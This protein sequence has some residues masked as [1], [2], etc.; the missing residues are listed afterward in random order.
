MNNDAIKDRIRKL[1]NLAENDG[2]SEG[3][4]EN[5]MRF[6]QRLMAEHHL[7]EADIDRNPDQRRTPEDIA[8]SKSY[9][10][11]SVPLGA[12]KMSYWEASVSNAVQRVFS[13]HVQCYRTHPT[14]Q[15][16]TPAGLP[17]FD[18]E[19]SP[20]YRT[21]FV[22]YGPAEE[23]RLCAELFQ[24]VCVS[25]ASMARLRYGSVFR[26]DGRSYA[27]GF[28]RALLDK[29]RQ[30]SLPSPST[31]STSLVLASVTKAIQTQAREDLHRTTG[32][33]LTTG[34]RTVKRNVRNDVAAYNQGKADGASF[35]LT[36]PSTTRKLPGA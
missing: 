32:V 36:R 18:D 19:G 15:A 21:C 34:P 35:D 8:S 16:K 26:G 13:D 27:E 9:T 14:G 23:T 5:A 6:A 29:V 33:K 25:I 20:V 2:A 4:I 17:M 22:F 30:P 3:E 10:H 28:A 1:L 11:V 31:T 12:S 24:T 7:D